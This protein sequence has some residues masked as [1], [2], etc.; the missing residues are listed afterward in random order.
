MQSADHRSVHTQAVVGEIA[1]DTAVLTSET[2]QLFRMPLALLPQP[3]AVGMVVD[4]HAAVN[5]AARA[6]REES[7]REV[8]RALCARLQL[9]SPGPAAQPTEPSSDTVPFSHP[10]PPLP[11]G[12]RL[13]VSTLPPAS[14]CA[15]VVLG[16]RVWK[17]A[18][19]LC[20]WMGRTTARS[21]QPSLV[22]ALVAALVAPGL[23]PCASA[24]RAWRLWAARH[25]QRRGRP[26][27]IPATASGARARRL[28]RTLRPFHRLSPSATQAPLTS[29]SAAR[30]WSWERA[31]EPVTVCNGACH[32]M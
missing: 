14:S 13:E 28:Q 10:L 27:G 6:E 9:P 26:A 18:P 8:Q 2:L 25:S 21:K 24:A 4:L 5:P 31:V 11:S 19:A 16:G 22:P 1:D 29:S 17:A 7:V 32:R 20:A 23:A 30:C 12:A 15:D 3:L